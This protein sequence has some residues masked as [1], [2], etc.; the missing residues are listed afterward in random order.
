MIS[1]G[2]SN[3]E[4]WHDDADNL[5]NIEQKTVLIFHNISFTVY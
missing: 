4:D 3:T 1:K 2:S 5:K